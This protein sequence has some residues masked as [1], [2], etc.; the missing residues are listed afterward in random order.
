MLCQDPPP[1]TITMTKRFF[2]FPPFQYPFNIPTYFPSPT[3]RRVRN[4]YFLKRNKDERDLKRLMAHWDQ[5]CIHPCAKKRDCEVKRRGGKIRT[6]L[7]YFTLVYK[8]GEYFGGCINSYTKYFW[9]RIFFPE[10]GNCS[11]LSVEKW[12]ERGFHF[13][14]SQN[15]DEKTCFDGKFTAPLMGVSEGQEIL[16]VSPKKED[17][18]NKRICFTY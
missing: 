18:I 15:P 17:W 12:L 9:R 11:D 1:R 16:F 7:S 14:S 6:A 8:S 10:K 5:K 13:I 3:P 4:V 2:L